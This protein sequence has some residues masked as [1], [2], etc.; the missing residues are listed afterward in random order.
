MIKVYLTYSRMKDYLEC[1]KRYKFRY[2]DK[3]KVSED[4]YNACTGTIKQKIVEILYNE[5][6]LFRE[7]GEALKGKFKK[8]IPDLLRTWAEDVKKGGNKLDLSRPGRSSKVLIEEID[9]GVDQIF[10]IIKQDKLL[11]SPANLN[12]SEVE[13][14][15]EGKNYT[16]KGRIDLV[17]GDREKNP[18][19][20]DGKDTMIEKG[21]NYNDPDQL[22]A[23]ALMNHH[24]FGVYPEKLGFMMFR[25]NTVRWIDP[26]SGLVAFDEKATQ[27]AS[28]IQAGNY[29]ANVGDACRWCSYKPK[30]REHLDWVS[31]QGVKEETF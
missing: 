4:L 2:V 5:D 11:V 31:S 18:V 15:Y 1:P 29:K 25:F 7:K 28:E 14:V 30:C 26:V 6:W 8:M 22:Y 16:L 24:Q 9:R 13:G 23:Y 3:E 20:V 17:I 12:R 19:I 10:H 27:V 21:I